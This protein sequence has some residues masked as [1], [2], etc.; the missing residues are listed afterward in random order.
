MSEEIQ[1]EG[2]GVAPGVLETIATLAAGQ[3]DGVVDVLTKGVAG[4]VQKGS[5]R[6]IVVGAGV[7]GSLAVQIHVSVRY[8][9]PLHTVAVEVQRAVSDALCSQTGQQVAAVDVF[10]D[11][12][13]FSEL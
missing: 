10:I 11:A 12:I 5:G 13:V 3:V 1:L 6:G 9:T 7:D 4:L 2:L 8:G